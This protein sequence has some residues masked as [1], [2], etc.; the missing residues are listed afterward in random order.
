[1]TLRKQ[2]Q[3]AR[4]A[5][6]QAFTLMEILI[7]VAIIVILAGIGTVALF[8]ALGRAKENEARIKAAQI[9]KAIGI[10][11]NDHDG[12]PPTSV[13]ALVQKDQYGGPWI[14]DEDGIKDPWGNFYQIDPSGNTFSNGAKPDVWTTAPGGKGRVG[15]FKG[16]R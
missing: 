3:V 12:Q 6:R 2:Q 11:M 9:E 7:V 15:N 4:Q 10:Y 16:Y 8:P 5:T 14:I 1:M 13:N